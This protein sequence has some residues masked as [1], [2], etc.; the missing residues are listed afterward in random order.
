MTIYHKSIKLI[1]LF[2]VSLFFNG[3][4]ENINNIEPDSTN[5]RLVVEGYISTDTTRHMVKLSKLSDALNK[6]PIKMISNATVTISD[7]SA[8]YALKEDITK[9]GTY[10]TDSTVF[11][12][13]GKTYSLSI[14]NVDVNDDGIAE[15]YSAKSVLKLVNA[16]D[17]IQIVYNGSNPNMRGWSVNLY[18]QD[19]GGGR[20]FYLIKVRKN[21]VLL[22]D[23]IFKYSITDNTGFEGRYYDGFQ[24]Y[25]LREER[26]DEKLVTGNMVSVEMYGITEE[27]YGFIYDYILDY[28]PKVPIFS[29]PSAN[30][31]TNIEPKDKAVGIFTAYSIKRKNIVYK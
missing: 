7:G 31:S 10:F 11:G 14:K 29:G 12:V 16:I 21:N 15:E 24:A 3:C 18:A 20:N 13:P 19:P 9:A 6:Q 2:C 5:A 17:S 30:I 23:S 27:Y 28:Y 25:M 8:V 22:T 26:A 4:T 1:A